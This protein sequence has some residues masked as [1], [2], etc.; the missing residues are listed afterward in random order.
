MSDDQ[1]G[2]IKVEADGDA[3]VGGD[4]VGRDKITSITIQEKNP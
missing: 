2:G 4:A 3:T 1:T